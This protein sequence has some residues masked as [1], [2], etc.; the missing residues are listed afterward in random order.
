MM[1][2]IMDGSGLL[3]VGCWLVQVLVLVLMLVVANIHTVCSD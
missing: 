3:A 2:A 1:T